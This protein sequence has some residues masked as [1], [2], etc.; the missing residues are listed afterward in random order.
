MS[1]AKGLESL[2]SKL[3]T[4][5]DNTDTVIATLQ[6][7]LELKNFQTDTE[8]ALV[9]NFTQLIPSIYTEANAN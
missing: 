4:R 5:E 6:L 7:L 9:P 1:E 2:I 8:A 3:Y